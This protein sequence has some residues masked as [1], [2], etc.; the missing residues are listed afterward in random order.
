MSNRG[1]QV[2]RF[3]ACLLFLLYWTLAWFGPDDFRG[4][5]FVGAVGPFVL[6][7]ALTNRWWS[8]AFVFAPVL[9]G[10]PAGDDPDSGG[11][12]QSFA[13]LVGVPV[14]VGAITVGILLRRAADLVVT[15]ATS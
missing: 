1:S 9:I 4:H 12:P 6:L 7:G 5:G 15:R 14:L 2:V 10:L 8:L 11:D 13:F 3:A